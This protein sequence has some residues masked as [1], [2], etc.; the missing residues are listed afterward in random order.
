M[1]F[2][3]PELGRRID[4]A[5]KALGL[6][7]G[8]VAAKTGYDERTIRNVISGKGARPR[9]VLD[10]CDC[11]RLKDQDSDQE[12]E[13]ASEDH[14]SYTLPQY[15]EY[16]GNYF[17]YRRSFSYK[18]NIIRSV[19]SLEWSDEKK[20]MVFAEH[21]KFASPQGDVDFSQDG[22][23]YVSNAIGLLH[24]VTRHE[25]AIRLVTLTRLRNARTM[26]GVV[27]TQAALDDFYQPATSAILFVKQSAAT[28]ESMVSAVGP[29]P[30]TAADYADINS[31][32]TDI[33]R[34]MF[35]IAIHPDAPNIRA[36]SG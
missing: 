6:T 8:E 31:R 3:Q 16:L 36:G 35:A 18:G 7:L 13:V 19:F 20:C 23:I 26:R 9:T 15:K 4:E 29:I 2:E 24:F 21:Q 33:E 17:S 12:I 1:G 32:L 5:R 27:L 11:V 28:L 14:G 10:I 34:K 22:E 25:G 30:T